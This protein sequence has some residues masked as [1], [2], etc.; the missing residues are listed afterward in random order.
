MPSFP[1]GGAARCA[2]DG[3]DG[4]APGARQGLGLP[5][6]RR[7][8][9]GRPCPVPATAAGKAFSAEAVTGSAQKCDP[10]SGIQSTI[11]TDGMDRALARDQY[12]PSQSGWKL[13]A[14]GE[15]GLMLEMPPP[16]G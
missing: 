6:P 16:S 14:L 7:A 5:S 12:L 11:T 8:G 3:T 1:N 10:Q 15:Y 9:D 13:P 4:A 2:L